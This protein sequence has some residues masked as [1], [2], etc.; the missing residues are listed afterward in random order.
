MKAI[1]QHPVAA[2]EQRGH[3]NA[4]LARSRSRELHCWSLLSLSCLCLTSFRR[5]ALRLRACVPR[6][7]KSSLS[8]LLASSRKS[9]ERTVMLTQDS[10][11]RSPSESSPSHSTST[12][13]GRPR[14]PSCLRTTMMR[15]TAHR[16]PSSAS[17]P[18]RTGP[19]ATRCRTSLLARCTSCLRRFTRCG[20][21]LG[22]IS[23]R[24]TSPTSIEACPLSV[25]QEGTCSGP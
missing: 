9:C 13:N 7:P 3:S 15:R 6:G 4:L 24:T 20:S 22:S 8:S 21:H 12:S 1:G 2:R 23:S 18:A 19:M 10:S 16:P 5:S 11:Q 14:R 17:C 25:W